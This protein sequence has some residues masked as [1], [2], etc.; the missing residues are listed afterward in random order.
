VDDG[1]FIVSELAG[2]AVKHASGTPF[3]VVVKTGPEQEPAIQVHD[4]CLKPPEL[5]PADFVSEGDRGLHVVDAL[6]E[7]WNCVPSGKG[8]AVIATLHRGRK[9]GAAG[10]FPG[11][12][13]QEINLEHESEG[14]DGAG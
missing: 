12:D 6:C 5:L 7:S 14:I 8:K 4:S 11:T 2:N 9:N 1:V 10:D 13:L 3:L